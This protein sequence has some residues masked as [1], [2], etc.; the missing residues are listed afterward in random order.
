MAQKPLESGF[1][2]TK[3]VKK[4]LCGGFLDL[5]IWNPHI[6]SSQTKTDSLLIFV[7]ENQVFSPM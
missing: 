6:K 3:R 7:D 1:L 2:M 4:A 5:H